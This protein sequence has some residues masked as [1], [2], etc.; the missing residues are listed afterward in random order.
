MM[1]YATIDDLQAR[2]PRD[3]TS[4]EHDRV[5][6]MLD[7]ASFML[8]VRAPGLQAAIDED[9]ETITTAAMLLVVAMVKRA[10]LA[11]AAQQTVN[12][13]VDSVAETWGTYSQSVKYR[14]NDGNLFLYGSELEYLLGLIRGVMA[15]AVSMRSPGL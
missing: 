8:S 14:S 10:L 12:P 5:P 4:E 9:D 6:T 3:L 13:A 15:Q 7:D 2:F 1:A 11:Q